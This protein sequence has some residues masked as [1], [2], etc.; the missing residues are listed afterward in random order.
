MELNCNRR[1]AWYVVVPL[2]VVAQMGDSE[3]EFV[4]LASRLVNDL[5]LLLADKDGS[6]FIKA[7]SQ[8]ASFYHSLTTSPP[9]SVGA[10]P[11]KNGNKKRPSRPRKDPIHSEATR[12]WG[13]AADLAE[14]LILKMNCLD[15][16]GAL[17][18]SDGPELI[19]ICLVCSRLWAK[20][21]TVLEMMR[22][23]L[24]KHAIYCSRECQSG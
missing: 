4:E 5:L 16:G 12:I 24:C 10:A 3:T 21:G 2:S 14:S 17:R 1:T 15:R 22:C 6:L 13:A 23:S 19:P 9:T 20:D 8:L 18:D 7:G 11:T